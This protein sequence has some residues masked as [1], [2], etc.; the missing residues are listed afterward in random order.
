MRSFRARYSVLYLGAAIPSSDQYGIDS[1][2]EP[3]SKRYPVDGSEVVRGK[4]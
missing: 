4:E 2:Q 1:I 3:I